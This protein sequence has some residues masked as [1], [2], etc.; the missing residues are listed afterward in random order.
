MP[1]SELTLALEFTGRY[2]TALAAVMGATGGMLAGW[3]A[4]IRARHEKDDECIERLNN[5]RK[6]LGEVFDK[7]ELERSKRLEAESKFP[8]ADLSGWGGEHE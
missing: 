5:T 3:A 8:G 7:W 4:I 2:L 1:L 6:E